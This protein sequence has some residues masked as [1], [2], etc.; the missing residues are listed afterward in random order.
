MSTNIKEEQTTT[1][2]EYVDPLSG[3]VYVQR[4]QTIT[5]TRFYKTKEE[6]I[7]I[8]LEDM[9]GLLSITSKTEL[10]IL[11]MLWKYSSF[12][13]EDN[14]GNFI[15]INS[16]V[17]NDIATNIGI[18]I[19]SVRNA[20]SSLIKNTNH[21]LIKDPTYRATYYLNPKYFFKGSLNDRPKVMKVINKYIDSSQT[22][23]P[24]EF[25]IKN[26]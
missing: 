26:E 17:I 18:K 10:Q 13:E 9:S 7:Q 3:E 23:I 8:Y 12:N 21:I 4:E 19:Q 6:F 24:D 11:M 16:K 14:S 1:L 22:D 20:I 2:K 5:N 25:A 15:I